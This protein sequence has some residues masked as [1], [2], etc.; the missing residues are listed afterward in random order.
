MG[1][2]TRQTTRRA[3][4]GAGPVARFSRRLVLAAAGVASVAC[5]GPTGGAGPTPPRGCVE[6]RAWPAFEEVARER[7]QACSRPTSEAARARC[8]REDYLEHACYGINAW[9]M[10]LGGDPELASFD[11]R[12]PWPE[13]QWID[14]TLNLS[15]G[16]SGSESWADHLGLAGY[17]DNSIKRRRRQVMNVLTLGFAQDWYDARGLGT[18]PD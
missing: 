18:P 16:H 3:A 12:F 11:V 6:E 8:E 15:P 9:R 7:D 5:Q 10:S 2:K 1:R 4:A 14:A 17:H 13:L